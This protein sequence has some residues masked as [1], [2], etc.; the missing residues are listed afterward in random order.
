MLKVKLKNDFIKKE[1]AKRNKS[2]NWLANHL[3]ISSGYMSQLL[4]GV[5]HPSPELRQKIQNYFKDQSFE[6]LF[7]FTE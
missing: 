5:K 4:N 6:D 1:L 3:R 7:S 2:Q